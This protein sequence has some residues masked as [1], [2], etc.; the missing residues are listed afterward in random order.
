M[1]TNCFQEMEQTSSP[2]HILEERQ[3]RQ[4]HD[5]DYDSGPDDSGTF[6]SSPQGS[7]DELDHG[8]R[9]VKITERAK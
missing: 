8:K 1:C 2:S 4:G 6:Q 7:S 3:E 5:K 9:R